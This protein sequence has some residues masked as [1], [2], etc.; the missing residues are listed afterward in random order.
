MGA[1]DGRDELDFGIM[2][3][4]TEFPDYAA[5]AITR[6]LDLD[7]VNL[8]LLVI[9]DG[10]SGGDGPSGTLGSVAGKLSSLRRSVAK[11]GVSETVDDVGW[12]LYRRARPTPDCHRITDLGDRLA[13]VDRIRCDPREEGFSTYLREADVEAIR[14]YDLDFLL[15]RAFGILRGEILE[16]PRYG[17]WSFHHDDEREYRGTPPGFWEIYE[18]RVVTGAI[19][20]RLTQRLDGGVVLR[21]GTF[22]TM[23]THP[24]N[25]DAVKYGSAPWP[26]QVATDILNG[27]A[28]YV[29]GEPSTTDAPVYTKPSPPQ[30]L[31]YELANLGRM[32]GSLAEGIDDWNVGVVDDEVGAFVDGDADGEVEWYAGPMEDAFVADPFAVDVDGETYVF[33]EEFDQDDAKGKIS[34]VALD[35]WPDGAFETAIE[36]PFHMSYP[37]AFRHDGAAYATPE[38]GEIDEVR[39]Y[40][41]DAP[42]EWAQVETLL[43]GVSASD[44]SVVRRDGRWWLFFTK[45][46]GT[47]QGHLTDLHVWHAP[48][49]TGE[50]EPHA[51][52]PV[53][54]DVRSAKSAGTLFERDGALYRPAQNCAGGYGQSVVLN[55]VTELTP[56][57]FAEESVVTVEPTAGGRYPEGLHTVAGDGEVTLVDGKRNVWNRVTLGRKVGQVRRNLPV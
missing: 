26:A 16:V 14:E 5:Q 34:Y 39:L 1:G 41:I 51:N 9:D 11:K 28:D 12:T 19:L 15:R 22:R 8:R 24:Q 48:E 47:P 3:A 23:R 6:L 42:A 53:K 18:R 21:R 35:D 52:N 10:G 7:R 13:G 38:T 30:L 29:D 25:L 2:C 46:G 56:T 49:L 20:Q 44:P 31:R 27:E 36:E 45:R 37:Y 57:G 32:A 50:W 33:V 4:G 55:R 54:T 17:V 43:T 40:R